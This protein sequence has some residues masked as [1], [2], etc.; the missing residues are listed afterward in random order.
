MSASLNLTEKVNVVKSLF[1]EKCKGKKVTFIILENSEEISLLEAVSLKE[2]NQAG[3]VCFI[4][5]HKWKPTVPIK[6]LYIK[7]TLVL[8]PFLNFVLW[9]LYSTN[10]YN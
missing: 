10:L 6:P 8:I 4:E 2:N 9:Y 1:N 3:N 5:N 7:Y